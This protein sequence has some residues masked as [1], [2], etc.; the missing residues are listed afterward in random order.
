MFCVCV[1]FLI[2]RPAFFYFMRRCLKGAT[3]LKFIFPRDTRASSFVSQRE[4]EINWSKRLVCTLLMKCKVATSVSGIFGVSKSVCVC[5]W[6]SPFKDKA[7][8]GGGD[9][10]CVFMGKKKQAGIHRSQLS[11]SSLLPFVSDSLTGRGTSNSFSETQ[12]L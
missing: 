12:D 8:G 5:V 6:L 3:Q 2:W 7:E 11:S 1:L 9:F 10:V 4:S